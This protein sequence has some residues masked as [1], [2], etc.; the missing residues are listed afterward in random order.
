LESL[1]KLPEKACIFPAPVIF[2]TLPKTSKV[3]SRYRDYSLLPAIINTPHPCPSPLE[4]DGKREKGF[5]VG[6]L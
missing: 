1:D 2:L 4:G 3:D 5:I 6:G